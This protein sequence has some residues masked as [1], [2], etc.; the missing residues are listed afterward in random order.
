[1]NQHSDHCYEFGPFRLDAEE[2]RLLREGEAVPLPPK[3]FDLLLVLVECHGHLMQKDELLKLVWPEM[4]VEEANLSY[5]VSLIRR[6]LGENGDEQR[7]IETVPKHGYRFVAEVR[8]APEEKPEP[9]I[10]EQPGSLEFAATRKGAL[11]RPAVVFALALGVSAAG[12][13]I[14]S[15]L[16]SKPPS[17]PLRVVPM[18]SYQGAE[19][20]PSFSPDGSQVAFTWDGEKQDNF[21]IYTRPIGHETPFRLTSDPGKDMSPAWSPDGRWIAF[22]R[23]GPDGKA[24]VFLTT[25]LSRAERQLTEIVSP[26]IRV[27]FFGSFLSW[28]PDCKWIVTADANSPGSPFGLVVISVKTG[29]KRTLTSPPPKGGNDIAPAFSPD[30]RLLAFI[31]ILSFPV[32]ELYLLGLTDDL[33]PKG[34][35]VRLTYEDRR[36]TSPVWSQDGREIIFASGDVFNSRLYRIAVHE[37][38]KPREIE[39]VGEAGPVLAISHAA[40]RLAY[41]REVFDPNIWRVQI[42]AD[43]ETVGAPASLIPSTRVDFNQQ[44]SPDGKKVAFVSNRSEHTEIWVCDSDGANVVRLTSFGGPL[45]ECPR[46]S[47][48]GERIVFQSHSKGQLDVFLIN[49]RGGTPER[50]TREPSDEGAPSWSRDGRWI[51]FH[52]NRSGTSQVWKMRTDGSGAVRVTKQ[53]G[54]AAFESPDRKFVYYSK[55]LAHGPALWRIPVDGGEETEVLTGISDWSTFALVDRGIYFVPRGEPTAPGSIQFLNF[56]DR[57]I[58]SIIPIAKPAFVGFTV[59][60]DGQSLL[61]TQLD[62]EG[63][64]L[65]LVEHFR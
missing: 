36:T 62:Q 59:S 53:G 38:G 16:T 30:G 48:D 6:A 57:R 41:V 51:Y 13:L 60:R 24:G 12:W 46:W 34:E 45:T 44:F 21:D 64:D 50:L 9:G 58:K 31:R 14:I 25:P 8:E 7:Y 26:W 3:A 22:L 5:N 56:A 15:G 4:F 10:A 63:S 43:G 35:P 39:W 55:G 65:M 1:M 2:R 29:E 27:G 20:F 54:F 52:S 11:V 40:R 37:P 18:T 32:S 28:S 61:Y 17:S 49:V 47:P 23:F 42:G 33:K 19:R